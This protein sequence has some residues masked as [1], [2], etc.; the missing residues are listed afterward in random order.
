M[1]ILTYDFIRKIAKA[2]E[3]EETDVYTLSLYSMNSDDLNYFSNADREKIRR[4]F[5]VLIEDTRHHADLL[6]LIVE[7]GAK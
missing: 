7:M 6:R 4:I 5:K 2:L 3:E 1:T